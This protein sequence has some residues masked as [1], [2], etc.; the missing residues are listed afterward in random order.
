MIHI[1]EAAR[2]GVITDAPTFQTIG[3]RIL[4]FLLSIAGVIAIMALVLSG[5]IYFF[6][7]GDEKRMEKAKSSAKYAATGIA[8]V[9][10]GM[11]VVKF[12]G[13]FFQ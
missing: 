6:S 1:I 2:A 10:G 5:I 9:L 8:L 7:A 4:N 13:Q 12:V 11:V 3:M